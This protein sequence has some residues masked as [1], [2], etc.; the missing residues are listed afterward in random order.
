VY[1]TQ[2]RIYSY[3]RSIYPYGVGGFGLG[4]FYYD[5]YL[6]GPGYAP[7]YDPYYSGGYYG[8]YDSGGGYATG[9]LRIDVRPRDAQV[10][11][12]GYYA[13]VVDDFDGV[14]QSLKLEEGPHTLRIVA[15][16]FEPLDFSIRVFAGR[17]LTYKGELLQR[18][19]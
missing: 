13:G 19:P 15:P 5:P 2:P 7:Y 3:P 18:R 17:K 9:E 1:G 4:Y 14:F 12:D 6:W 8:G 10:Y 11:V 16:G